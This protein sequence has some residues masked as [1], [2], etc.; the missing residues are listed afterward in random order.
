MPSHTVQITQVGKR[1][2]ELSNLTKILYP[3][4]GIS[5]AE[6]VEYYFKVAPTI[7]AHIK[8]RPLSLVRFPDGITGESFFQKNRPGWAP[9][10][11]E[12]VALG[13][14]KKDYVIAT[15]D[16]SLVWLANLACIELHQMHCRAP[17]FDKPDYIAYDFDPPET[18]NFPDV[19]QLAL[20]FKEHLESFGY[21]PF[22]K[23]TGRKGLHVVTPV[24]AKWG[25]EDA[26]EA[27]KA[28]AQ[29]FVESH[30]TALTLQIKKDQRKGKVLLD[31]YRN[32]QSQTIVAAYSGRGLPGAT[33][34]TPLSWEELRG[35]ES[36]K[37]FNLR[38]VQ[39]R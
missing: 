21:H 12:H 18:F 27:A 7:L 37:E 10:W 15:E 29:P 3:D 30:Q 26:F 39:Q 23:T 9:D 4:D 31:I 14:E 20:E 25:F 6:L 1:K 35:V 24:E 17:H 5:K 36:P 19:A 13:Q 22:V 32:R 28:V 16:A 33:V 11:I 34:S 38:T 2:I 8:G